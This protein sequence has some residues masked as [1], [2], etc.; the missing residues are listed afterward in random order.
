MPGAVSG[1]GLASVVK[2]AEKCLGSVHRSTSP[3]DQPTDD[4]PADN[5]TADDSTADHP[6]CAAAGTGFWGDRGCLDQFQSG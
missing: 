2:I 1:I 6:A 4:T 3:A 5:S